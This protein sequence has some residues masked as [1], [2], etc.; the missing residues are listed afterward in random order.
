[1]TV[2]AGNNFPV[3]VVRFHLLENA[4]DHV[5]SQYELISL[6]RHHKSWNDKLKSIDFNLQI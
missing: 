2:V 1:I 3:L 6:S 5:A 4:F